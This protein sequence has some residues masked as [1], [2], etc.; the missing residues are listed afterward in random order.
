[1]NYLDRAVSTL[2]TAG[3]LFQPEVQEAP[4][5]KLL[6]KVAK[7]DLNKVASIAATLQQSSAFNAVIREKIQGMEIS[8]RF[9]EIC[10]FHA[11][12]TLSP[13]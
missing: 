12:R 3:I 13:R 6:D 8:N 11:I 1:M 7:Y 9:A 2:R 4:V 5:L 10:G